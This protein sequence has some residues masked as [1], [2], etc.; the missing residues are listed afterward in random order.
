MTPQ[1]LGLLIPEHEEAVIE[2]DVIKIIKFAIDH[3]SQT[4]PGVADD[5]ERRHP[6]QA[7]RLALGDVMEGHLIPY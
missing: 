7:R 4:D 1:G 2:A 3:R 5:S 6:R